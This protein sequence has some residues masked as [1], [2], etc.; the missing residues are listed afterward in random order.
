MKKEESL[1]LSESMMVWGLENPI[2]TGMTTCVFEK[3][4]T[5]VECVS[6]DKVKLTFMQNA[7]LPG[8]EIKLV[9][10]DSYLYEM[11]K[12]F[13]LSEKELFELT[14]KISELNLSID[15]NNLDFSENSVN[16]NMIKFL[17]G[18]DLANGLKAVYKSNK[19]KNIYLD[20]T[21]DQFL[22]DSTGEIF[23]VDAVMDKQIY[24]IIQETN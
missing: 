15:K 13:P 3:S 22:K 6:I 11:E 21:V 1:A 8:F 24:R 9:A 18:E 7:N 23:C 4:E 12:L 20:I 17:F 19:A 10:E 16:L 5:Q 14:E 2:S